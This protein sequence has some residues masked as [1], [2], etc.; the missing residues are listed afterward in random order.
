MRFFASAVAV[1]AL[2]DPA[3]AQLPRDSLSRL[4]LA[5]C[6]TGMVEAQ[7]VLPDLPQK[8]ELLRRGYETCDGSVIRMAA[9]RDL[10]READVGLFACAYAMG[11][12][13]AKYGFGGEANPPSARLMNS[14][15][16]CE[17]VLWQQNMLSPEEHR[18][19]APVALRR[20]LRNLVTAEEVYFADSVRYTE[21]VAQLE[22]IVPFTVSVSVRI[23]GDGY[24]A[25]ATDRSGVI[26]HLFIGPEA[27]VAGRKEAEPWCVTK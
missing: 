11:A 23:L 22:L 18:R 8:D 14:Y 3:S 19:V 1:L 13:F 9:T 6:Y 5:A 20:L 27:A 12:M 7:K 10:E 17:S 26:C 25:S 16:E 24:R 4:Y 2:V 21:D 15:L